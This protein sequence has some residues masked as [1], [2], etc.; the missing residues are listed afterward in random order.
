[1][2]LTMQINYANN[3]N[4]ANIA[5]AST[6][7]T[8]LKK[9][10]EKQ[11]QAVSIIFNQDRFTYARPL[12]RTQ[13]T[14][15][16]QINFLQVLLFMHKIKTSSSP[17]IFLHQ[18]QRINHNYTTL[19]SWNNFK[20]PKRESNYAKYCIHVRGPVIRNSFLNETEKIILSQHF[21]ERKIK[22]KIIEFE[23]VI[24]NPKVSYVYCISF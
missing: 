2:I 13:K 4:Y 9:L 5:W 22:S 17:R 24:L 20:E 3:I 7:K 1:M 19:Y 10:F 14:Q 6:N 18:F 16:I 23:E 8:K 21:F 11:K 12:L 15:K